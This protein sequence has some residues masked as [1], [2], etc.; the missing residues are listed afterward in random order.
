MPTISTNLCGLNGEDLGTITPDVIAL[1]DQLSKAMSALLEDVGR[2][3]APEGAT[4][5]N[6]KAALEA[7]RGGCCSKRQPFLFCLLYNFS[8]PHIDSM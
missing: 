3:L 6:G 1:R 5:R 8:L 7:G 4:L 2:P